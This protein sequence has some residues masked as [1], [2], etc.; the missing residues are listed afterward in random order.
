VSALRDT[1]ST[2]P[3]VW[4]KASV[5]GSLWASVEIVAGAFLRNFR[6]P[7]CRRA[8]QAANERPQWRG[9]GGC[10]GKCC[11]HPAL[12]GFRLAPVVPAAG[13][14]L[15]VTVVRHDAAPA[16]G[17]PFCPGCLFE[18]ALFQRPPPIASLA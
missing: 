9:S 11:E 1:P 15:A 10:R 16:P 4:L 13:P 6:L 3:E 12:P 17:R 8:A 18:S 5:L 7:V 14:N 2:L